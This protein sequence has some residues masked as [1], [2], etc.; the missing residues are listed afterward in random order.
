MTDMPRKKLGDSDVTKITTVPNGALLL[1]ELSTG[2]ARALQ[3]DA[4]GGVNPFDT[5]AATLAE[6]KAV[7]TAYDAG[8]I[9]QISMGNVLVKI[10]AAGAGD[11][12]NNAGTWGFTVLTGPTF[13]TRNAANAAEIAAYPNDTDGEMAGI[14]YTSDNTKTG[15][16]SV[17]NDLSVDGLK[18]RG[19]IEMG[20]F[21]GS[22]ERMLAWM[23]ANGASG[24][25]VNVTGSMTFTAGARLAT[26]NDWHFDAEIDYT[27][28]ADTD[29][30]DMFGQ[31]DTHLAAL[32]SKTAMPALA[33]DVAAGDFI[34]T[35]AS[36]H[37]LA[38]DDVFE[39]VNR[40]DRSWGQA[41]ASFRAGQMCRVGRV[42]SS[43]VV[44]IDQP[45]SYAHAAADMDCARYAPWTGNISGNLKII[46]NGSSARATYG[47]GI[48]FF[49]RIS[50]QGV[51]ASNVSYIPISIGRGIDFTISGSS[52]MEDGSTDFAGDYGVGFYSPWRGEIHNVHGVAAR[53]GITCGNVDGGTP[54]AFLKFVNCT[55]TSHGDPTE[56]AP[57]GDCHAVG[58]DITWENCRFPSG[59]TDGAENIT[60]TDCEF[61]NF[62]GA[63][64]CYYASTYR[65]GGKASLIRPKFVV[66]GATVT[67]THGVMNLGISD[68]VF[69]YLK[70]DFTYL[71]RDAEIVG[72]PTGSNMFARIS[73]GNATY[74]VNVDIDGITDHNTTSRTAILDVLTATGTP[75]APDYIGVKGIRKAKSGI[76]IAN[77]PGG[78]TAPTAYDF[79][80]ESG[81][82]SS[83]TG[84]GFSKTDVVAFTFD[85]PFAPAVMISANSPA[86]MNSG[87][88]Y[89]VGEAYGVTTDQFTAIARLA[90]FNTAFASDTAFTL[91]WTATCKKGCT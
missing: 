83:S 48:D 18:P 30:I 62:P 36:A 74:K 46:G 64:Y 49:S 77:Y 40:N 67:S 72:S 12:N 78:V 88:E 34:L 43:T 24:H 5:G 90:D 7:T 69:D 75:I 27:G 14:G 80:S 22:A 1:V 11:A 87:N 45:V 66:N 31:P 50:V 47:L 10:T 59:F 89:L 79:G 68:D 19:N 44:W 55:A 51:S 3:Y 29:L 8:S 9:L 81:I 71:V 37:G 85:F 61:H 54:F 16:N 4:E 41:K 26:G 84:T 2:E 53:H 39:M 42:V 63:N 17:T 20:H 60:F 52:G 82:V 28:V 73:F 38:Q 35:F 76:N 23:Y 13:A 65:T 21:G 86:N 70:R 32:G 15:T 6:F 25:R 56:G 57:G 91:G 33:S 58:H